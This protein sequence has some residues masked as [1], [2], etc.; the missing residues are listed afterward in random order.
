LGLRA[1]RCWHVLIS[2]HA[3]SIA[4]DANVVFVGFDLLRR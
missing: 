1:E 4:K 3:V 2:P